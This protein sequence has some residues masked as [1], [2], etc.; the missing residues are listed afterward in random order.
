MAFELLVDDLGDVTVV[1]GA[2]LALQIP[3]EPNLIDQALRHPS[4]FFV[5]L[6]EF[7]KVPI[8]SL[9]QVQVICFQLCRAHVELVLQ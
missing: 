8:E 5:E 3:D 9:D 6:V 4:L 2:Q 7:Q 1:G